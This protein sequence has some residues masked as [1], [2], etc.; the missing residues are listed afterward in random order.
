MDRRN[1]SVERY[2]ALEEELEKKAGEAQRLNEK[3][4]IDEQMAVERHERK[5]I[6]KAKKAELEAA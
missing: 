2:Y 1:K 4:A 5:T 6:K 3:R